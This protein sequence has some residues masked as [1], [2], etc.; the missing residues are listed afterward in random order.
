M[1]KLAVISLSALLL[2][3]CG[4][5]TSGDQNGKDTTS[6]STECT[7]TTDCCGGED[8]DGYEAG[9]DKVGYHEIVWY[10][11]YNSFKVKG[12]PSIESFVAAL[13][14]AV[15]DLLS[16]EEGEDFATLDKANGY[17]HFYQ[18]GAG[19]VEY[20][21]ALWNRKDGKKLFIF[22]YSEVDEIFA[23]NAK[24]AKELTQHRESMWMYFDSKI[25]EEHGHGMLYD[26]GFVAY[27]YDDAKKELVPLESSPFDGIN[28]T[29]KPRFYELPRKGK[30]IKVR[31]GLYGDYSYSTLKWNGTGF[32]LE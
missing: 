32:D 22:S 19:S 9:A 23:E 11:L 17:F 7:D 31:E 3:S 12:A 27:I 24:Q 8:E 26:N 4:N 20:D 30:D 13:E 1:K 18:E 2:A 6:V 15:G 10:K 16:E 21:G 29:D 14:P 5:S 25:E 28:D